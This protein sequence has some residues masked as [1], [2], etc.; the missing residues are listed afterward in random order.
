MKSTERTPPSA[1]PPGRWPW[2]RSLQY[3]IVLTYGLVFLAV[4]ILLGVVVGQIIYTTQLDAA[5]HDLELAAFLTANALED[6]LSGFSEEFDQ[7]EKWER[8]REDDEDEREDDDDD[9][10]EEEDEEDERDTSAQKAADGSDDPT[11]GTNNSIS[12][13]RLLQLAVQSANDTSAHVTILDIHGNAVAD[14]LYPITDVTNQLQQI[15]V[16]SAIA[17]TEQHEVR[18]DPLSGEQMLYAAAPI[19]QGTHLLGVVQMSRTTD[20]IMEEI[21]SVETKLIMAGL[22]AFFV[23]AALGILISRRLVKPVRQLEAA[24][25][26]TASGDFSH[27]VDINRSDE[28]GALAYAFNYMVYELRRMVEQQRAFVANA[29]HELRTPLTNIKLR[30]EILLSV[31]DMEPELVERYLTEIDSEADRLSRLAAILLDLSR[32]EQTYQPE[33]SEQMV[34]IRPVVTSVTGMM[35]LRAEQKKVLLSTDLPEN[36]PSLRIHPEHLDAIL[37]NLIDNAIKYTPAAGE[38]VVT[39]QS[40]GN[41]VS[42]SVQD[43]GP[44]IPETDLP[45]IFDPFYRVDRAR[46]R[47]RSVYAGTGSGTGLGLGIVKTLV[48]QNGGRIEVETGLKGS[49]FMVFFPAGA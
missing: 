19:Q 17:G 36:L 37:I 30:S 39:A 5:E 3:R 41:E 16:Q 23:S 22:I 14:S 48:E 21:W 10:E 4:L 46:S 18:T 24:A 8:G 33:Q 49:R 38:V 28:L 9:E 15:E 6:P 2:Q 44:G 45:R 35:Q 31:D 27:Q 34:E 32:L 47:Q 40:D 42:L 25:I 11:I 43:S 1:P 26:V 12:L 13:P 20:E 29:S 7:Y